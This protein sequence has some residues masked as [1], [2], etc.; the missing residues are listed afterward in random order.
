MLKFLKSWK[1][2]EIVLEDFLRRCVTINLLS[3]DDF[4]KWLWK[5]N[6][7]CTVYTVIVYIL[8]IMSN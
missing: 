1:E 6:D 5:M 4:L 3:Y 2:M 8:F 7:F